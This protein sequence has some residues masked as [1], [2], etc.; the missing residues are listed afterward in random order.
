MAKQPFATKDQL[1]RIAL[2]YPTPFHIYDERMNRARAKALNAAFA[3]NPGFC[4]FFAVKATPN[5]AIIRIQNEEG[6]GC[7]CATMTELMLAHVAGVNG[8]KV[9]LREDGTVR[10]IRRAEKPGDYFA[11]LDIDPAFFPALSRG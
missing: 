2:E 1:E 11:A 9:M 3:W 5:P 6:F 4:E 10:L 7:D 8:R